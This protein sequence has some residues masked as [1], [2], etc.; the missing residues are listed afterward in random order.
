MFC[1]EKCNNCNISFYIS[2]LACER[3]FRFSCRRWICLT[4]NWQRNLITDLISENVTSLC[5]GNRWWL[6]LEHLILIVHLI[7]IYFFFVPNEILFCFPVFNCTSDHALIITQ[8]HYLWLI[9]YK[10]LL[11]KPKQKENSFKMRI[12]L[13]RTSAEQKKKTVSWKLNVFG[14]KHLL[15]FELLLCW[16]NSKKILQC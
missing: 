15:Y 10:N 3:H 8:L 13:C 11:L 5:I 6:F 9:L 4:W 14:S 2:C 12:N 7:Y 16:C 1:I